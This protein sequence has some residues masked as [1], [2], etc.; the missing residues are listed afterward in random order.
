MPLALI[1]EHFMDLALLEAKK[2]EAA[3]EVPVGAI[4]VNA[5]GTV[6]GRGHN[7]PIL[8]TDPSAHAEIVALREAARTLGNYRLAGAT[9]YCTKEPCV[10]CAGAIVH[11]RIARLVLGAPDPKAGAAGSIYNIVADPRLN[12]S[13]EVIRG[14][15]DVESSA[16]LQAFFKS[17]R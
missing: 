1:H 11:T 2:A 9:L 4:L 5:D 6:I 12:H 8:S 16:L 10:M 15:R 7:Q 14:I 13:V 17:R 3:D